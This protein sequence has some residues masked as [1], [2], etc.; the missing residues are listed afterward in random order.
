LLV[1]VLAL[2]QV[3]LAGVT[4]FAIAAFVHPGRPGITSSEG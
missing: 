2:V 3:L 1:L 4:V